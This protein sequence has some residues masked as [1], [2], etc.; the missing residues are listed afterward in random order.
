MQNKRKLE[1]NMKLANGGLDK[2]EA[3]A[4]ALKEILAKAIKK[5]RVRP[6][7]TLPPPTLPPL[8]PS[9]AAGFDDRIYTAPINDVCT[10]S[11]ANPSRYQFSKDVSEAIHSEICAY[12]RQGDLTDIVLVCEATEFPTDRKSVV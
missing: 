9:P 11:S 5:K 6:P 12:F 8:Q 1:A 2:Q 4:P 10:P 3:P 7:R